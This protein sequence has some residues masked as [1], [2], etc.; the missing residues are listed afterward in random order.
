[1][2]KSKLKN[3]VILNASFGGN[4]GAEAMLISL[5]EYLR[6]RFDNVNLY[7][8]KELIS[9]EIEQYT[10]DIIIKYSDYNY[11]L[12][13][14]RF[15][16]RKIIS[17][18]FLGYKSESRRIKADLVIDIGGLSFPENSIRASIRTFMKHLPFILR[19]K[20][21]IFFTQ[22]FGPI[23]KFVNKVI[24][25]KTLLT[26]KA[27][28]VRSDKSKTEVEKLWIRKSKI[29]GPFPDS[30]LTLQPE[31][32]L[33]DKLNNLTPYV[34]VSP[35]VVMLVKHGNDYL[36]YLIETIKSLQSNFKVILLAHGFLGQGQKGDDFVCEK[37]L[38]QIEDVEYIGENI[39]PRKF[40]YILSKAKWVI[41]SRYHAVVG[42]VSSGVP[43]IAIGWNPK[44]ESFLNLYG[45][46]KLNVDFNPGAAV[47][48]NTLINNFD[49]DELVK[50]IVSRNVS[51]KEKAKESFDL[52]Y[53]KLID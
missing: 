12:Y 24:A 20:R 15:I 45:L 27:I 36:K 51:L 42:A 49:Y 6:T 16:P 35:S 13:S 46:K 7:I 11:R 30:T 26:A 32:Y 53:E 5:G 3:I 28:F 41:S 31:E 43:A 33:S 40:K 48:I 21:R 23:N 29:V 34:V 38:K 52:L 8:E 4:K 47:E 2:T 19:F 44:Y 10:K 9:D 39:D 18:I 22:D 50:I 25:T 14:F 1:M 37:L 17:Q